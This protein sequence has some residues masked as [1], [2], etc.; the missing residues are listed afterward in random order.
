MAFNEW[1]KITLLC[2]ILGVWVPT[3]WAAVLVD[4]NLHTVI[5]P[6][7]NNTPFE[8]VSAETAYVRM[9]AA[10]TDLITAGSA[11]HNGL[12]WSGGNPGPA[13]LNLQRWD[14][15]NDNPSQFGDGSGTPNNWLQFYLTAQNEDVT[16]RSMIISAWRNGSGAAANWSFD[17]SRDNGATWTRFGHVHTESHAGDGIFRT[18]V[19]E[20]TLQ[21]PQ[22]SSVLIRFVATGGPGLGGSGNIHINAMLLADCVYQG[23]YLRTPSHQAQDLD[24]PVEFNWQVL[25]VNDSQCYI[26]IARGSSDNV[27]VDRRPLEGGI[28]YTLPD[29]LFTFGAAYFWKVDVV[30]G[31]VEIPGDVWSFTTRRIEAI[32]PDPANGQ[33]IVATSAYLRWDA[34]PGY[35]FNL[36]F[37]Q[38]ETD[39]SY[40]GTYSQTAAGLA[41]VAKAAAIDYLPQGTYFWRV[42]LLDEQG[43]TRSTGQVWSF[44][45]EQGGDNWIFALGGYSS[46]IR[47]VDDFYRYMSLDELTA[48]WNDGRANGTNS[49]LL[50][51]LLS[52]A[53]ILQYDNTAA[54]NR[55][56]AQRLFDP[57]RD[58][59]DTQSALVIGFCGR[60]DDAGGILYLK[61][62]DTAQQSTIVRCHHTAALQSMDYQNWTVRLSRTASEIDLSRIASLA[63][64]I[65]GPPSAG[66]KGIVRIADISLMPL[67]MIPQ[68]AA[69]ADLNQDGRVDETD[70]V[71]WLQD[72][73]RTEYTVYSEPPDESLLRVCYMFEE[74]DGVELRDASSHQFDGFVQAA[75]PDF[76]D[77]AGYQGRSLKL[78]AGSW[79]TIPNGIFDGVTE[80]TLSLWSKSINPF[81]FGCD[82]SLEYNRLGTIS[83]LFLPE[84][85]CRD[86]Q[87]HHLALV[88]SEID[89]RVYLDGVLL[90]GIAAKGAWTRPLLNTGPT[91]LKIVPNLC[92]PGA[93][94]WLD[95]L[96]IYAY[97]LSPSE[98]AYLAWGPSGQV[99]QPLVAFLTK[100]DLD[101]NGRIDLGDLAVLADNWLGCL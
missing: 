97:A 80:F 4:W 59:S 22:G 71:F 23:I 25:G 78:N 11:G 47:P 63:V 1:R 26:T 7:V 3:S 33:S 89:V 62:T 94:T 93:W 43:Q 66:G 55:S 99:T 10:V 18:V 72:W 64:G 76:R 70:L 15:P 90:D 60:P 17:Y 32:H 53:L 83:V 56:E 35:R 49:E 41:K 91:R 61:L 73:L 75:E 68:T 86:G 40:V 81:D 67:A 79:I 36:F 28:T 31:A 38:D 6:S 21:I 12:V 85:V 24:A 101:L 57:P 30:D 34:P 27:I 9:E 52:G 77:S 5:G 45:I 39:L 16:V 100:S 87:W 82:A 84:R 88:H 2:V 29:A 37:G 69:S 98:V 13:Q 65:E 58:F 42:D 20:D 19:F 14:H 44:A 46:P 95:T 96:R 8:G 54:P 48:V 51:E 92:A 50:F 74:V